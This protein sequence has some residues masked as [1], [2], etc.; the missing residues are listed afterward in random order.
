MKSAIIGLCAVYTGLAQEQWQWLNPLPQGN[1][2]FGVCAVGRRI[3]AVGELGTVLISIDGG[4]CWQVKHRIDNYEGTLYDVELVDERRGWAVGE[5]GA[6]FCSRNGGETFERQQ[7]PLQTHLY[8]VVFLDSL[9]GCAVGR[10][11][12]IIVTDDGGKHW[13]GAESGVLRSLHAVCRLEGDRLLAVGRGGTVLLSS[14]AGQSWKSVDMPTAENL[15]CVAYAMGKAVAA[16][17]NGIL[18]FSLDGGES[19]QRVT[20]GEK[21]L[22]WRCAAVSGD[23]LFILYGVSGTK[24]EAAPSGELYFSRDA[25]EWQRAAVDWAPSIYAVRGSREDLWMVG[26]CGLVLRWASGAAAPETLSSSIAESLRAS[27]FVDERHVRLAGGQQ[28]SRTNDGGKTWMTVNLNTAHQL[29]SVWFASADTGWVVGGGVVYRN[30]FP[31]LHGDF[32]FTTDG[33]ETWQPQPTEGTLT[34]LRSIRFY[35]RRIG[36]TVGDG[37]AL[38]KTSDGGRTWR[39]V[40]T[41]TRIKLFDVHLFGENHIIACGEGGRFIRSTDGGESWTRI[42]VPADSLLAMKFVDLSTG[43]AVGSGGAIFKT[44]NQGIKWEKID[45]GVFEELR[46]IDFISPRVGWAV[47]NNGLILKTENSGQDWIS[48]ISSTRR[49]FTSIRVHP[50]GSG[51]IVGDG[52]TVLVN[53]RLKDVVRST[54]KPQHYDL[55]RV[56]PNPFNESA[57][58][59][60]KAAHGGPIEIKVYNLLGKEVTTL[61]SGILEEGEHRFIFNAGNLPSGLYFCRL[62]TDEKSTVQKMMLYK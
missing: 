7:T 13:R 22:D 60:F 46:S 2:L 59:I 36:C 62:L 12:K 9:R 3:V 30:G 31:G 51:I 54:G 4:T 41:K 28:I 40:D 8:D 37:G 32:F 29:Y 34:R 58:I 24:G 49:R 39:R 15:R 21:A 53:R 42:G 48:I 5:D 23:S 55:L 43:Y 16:G 11:G 45:A 35:N 57:Q 52:G 27:F 26:R 56:F 33:G 38:F 50:D 6:V 20:A 14:D 19:W 17:D 44:T 61:F 47:G 18:F 10:W 25:V 1:N